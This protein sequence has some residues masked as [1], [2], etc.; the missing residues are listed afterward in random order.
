MNTPCVGFLKEITI[1][2][3]KTNMKMSSL[4]RRSLRRAGIGAGP[5]SS[6]LPALMLNTIGLVR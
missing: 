2:F 6:F 1:W 5:R 4:F 3:M